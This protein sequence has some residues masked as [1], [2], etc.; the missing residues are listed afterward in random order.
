LIDTA[1]LWVQAEGSMRARRWPEALVRLRKLVQVV[2]RIDFEYEEWLRAMAETLKALGQFREAAA[3][4]AYLGSTEPPGAES[5][6]RLRKQIEDGDA[7]SLRGVQLFGI[8]LAR[9]GHHDVAAQWFEVAD[10]P[11]HRAIELERAGKDEQAAELWNRM[12]QSD[13]FGR[14]ERGAPSDQPYELALAR[15]NYGLCLHRVE[16]DKRRTQAEPS[17]ARMALAEATTAVEEVADRFETEGLRERAF[18]C[19]QLLARIGLETGAFENVAEGYLNSVRILRDDALKLDALRL[20]EAFVTLARRSGEFHAVAGIL[21][22]A[23]DYCTRAGLPYGDDLRLRCGEA[24]VKAAEDAQVHGHP[25]QIVENAYL[26]AAEAYV[27][28]RAFRH[29]A[30]VYTRV[31]GLEIKGRERYHRLLDRLGKHP[32]DP[33][34]PI[35]VPEF[36]K[37]L[38]DYEEVWYVDLAEWELD[39]NPALIAAGIMADRRFPDYVRRH[40]LLLVL[41]LGRGEP[42]GRSDIVARLK[43]I[44]AYPVI[45]ALERTYAAGDAKVQREVAEALGALR[46]KRSFSTLAQALRSDDP[47][48]RTKAAEAIKNLYFPHAFDPLRRIFEAR[49][50]PDPESAR[51]A[52]I[53]AI[54]RI[55]TVE[56]LDFLC[57]RLREGEPRYVEHVKAAISE[58]TNA[59][60]GPYLRQQIDLVPPAY[61]SVLEDAAQR[62]G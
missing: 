57:D 3:C 27:S 62:L 37:R 40:A 31:A 24:W 12:I 54:G 4:W 9:A 10:M 58:L 25:V 39:G 35:P 14:S 26:A 21:R 15:I 33:P 46:F 20:Y 28:I 44:R 32:D 36:L 8:Y 34:R 38:P 55:N 51:V 42:V 47:V 13:R 50:I 56:A 23:A 22:E 43:S 60:L 7:E 17:R 19:Y 6:A 59:D 30:E 52:A 45:A 11:I 1:V 48:V 53:H 41:E 49:D 5:L 2:D 61:R 16:Q 18:D 29:A